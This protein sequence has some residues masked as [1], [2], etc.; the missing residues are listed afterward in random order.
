MQPSPYA[1]Q[2]QTKTETPAKVQDKSCP[3]FRYIA[4]E[5]IYAQGDEVRRLYRLLEGVVRTSRC[6]SDGRRQVGGFYYPG[7]VFGLE[8]GH[9]HQYSAEA[10]SDCRLE[11]ISSGANLGE[12]SAAL[13]EITRQ[14]LRKASDHVMLLGRKTAREKVALFLMSYAA[15]NRDADVDLPMGRQ[16]IA[17][18]LGLTVETVSRMLTQLQG[19]SVIAFPA[20]RRFQ[21]KRWDVLEE[22]AA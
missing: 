3:T 7:D 2:S 5:E 11:S 14:E 8:M 18:Y 17:D 15:R 19:E 21:L 6:N 13:A 4:D 20:V 16:D 10:L 9:E 22:L 1:G 12:N